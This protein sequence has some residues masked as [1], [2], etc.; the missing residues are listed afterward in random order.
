MTEDQVKTI[1]EQLCAHLAPAARQPNAAGG[2]PTVV[3]DLVFDDNEVK[4]ALLIGLKAAGIPV[5][6]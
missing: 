6:P 1:V 3:K 5:V 2:K 4:T